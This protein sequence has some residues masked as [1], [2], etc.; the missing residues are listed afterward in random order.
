M[1]YVIINQCFLNIWY[2]IEHKLVLM[3]LL[4]LAFFSECEFL[5]NICTGS[6]Y[7]VSCKCVI[8]IMFS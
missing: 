1:V 7:S 3:L 2:L 8:V 4:V 6:S 5:F